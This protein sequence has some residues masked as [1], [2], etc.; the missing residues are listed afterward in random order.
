MPSVK[1]PSMDSVEQAG[2]QLLK[3]IEEMRETLQII[4]GKRGVKIARLDPASA[5]AEDCANKLNE[6]LDLLQ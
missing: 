5:T 3:R 2:T 6:I 1:K 4:T